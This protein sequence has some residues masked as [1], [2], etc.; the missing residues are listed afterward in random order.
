[1]NNMKRR[2]LLFGTTAALVGAGLRPVFAQTA[3]ARDPSLLT[4]TLTPFGAERAGN[5]DGTIPAWTG[6]ITSA[7]AGYVSGTPRPDPFADDKVQFSINA[8]NVAQYADKL[9]QGA[10]EMMKRYPTYRVDVY[11][12]HRPHALPNYVYDN[13]ARNVT[14]AQLSADGTAVSGAFGG[15]P[16]PIPA[17]GSE[18]MWNHLTSYQGE[19]LK[20]LNSNYVVASSGQKYLASLATVVSD[21]PYYHKDASAEDFKGIY[22]QYIVDTI[23]P[24]YQ[25]GVAILAVQQLD[26]KA[27]PP[28]TMQ[29]LPGQRRVREAPDLA[30]DNPNFLDGGVGNFDETFVYDGRM[31]QYDFKLVGKKEIYV[32]YN[33]NR[34]FLASYD[35]Q[36]GPHHYNPDVLRWELHRVWVVEMT[37]LPGA[38]NV[39]ARRVMYVDEDC[40]VALACDIYDA[41]GAYWKFLH[42]FVINA[43]ELPTTLANATNVNYDLHKGD[44]AYNVGCDPSVTEL[45]FKFTPPLAQSYFSSQ[46]L[47][48]LQG[49][50]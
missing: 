22:K 25:A 31:D 43:S 1:M 39:D 4:T 32:P 6:G 2:S 9:P 15:V 13:I 38:R 37:L 5:A 10:V 21:F 8:Q 3:P 19:G 46:T 11:P 12:T 41:S 47:V 35:T 24:A 14:R 16:F 18:V 40:W 45:Q 49:G 26:S 29:Y 36:L 34:S 7:P 27:H 42:A 30:Y 23:A 28:K 20:A 33:N 48:S 50:N 17:N 44:Y